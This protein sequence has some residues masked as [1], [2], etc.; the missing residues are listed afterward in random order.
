MFAIIV[1]TLQFLKFGIL[2]Q[3]LKANLDPN[4]FL[5]IVINLMSTFRFKNRLG[6]AAILFPLLLVLLKLSL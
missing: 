1:S 6:L 3:F 4:L 5:A 2:S